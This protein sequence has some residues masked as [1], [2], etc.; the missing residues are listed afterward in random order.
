MPTKTRKKNEVLLELKDI[1]E[2]N[3]K[4]EAFDKVRDSTADK[5]DYMTY[6]V[7]VFQSAKQRIEFIEK[8]PEGVE[9]FEGIYVDG[10]GFAQAMDIPIKLNKN[11]P[12]KDRINKKREERAK[13]FRE[14]YDTL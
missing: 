13:K 7:L 12:L 4:L 1:A 10:Q 11:P 14:I 2:D 8:L 5:L 9:V 6:A 3:K